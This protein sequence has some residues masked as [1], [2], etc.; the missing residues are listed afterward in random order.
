M[1]LID[2]GETQSKTT[3]LA[4]NSDYFDEGGKRNRLNVEFIFRAIGD[5]YIL[6]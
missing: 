2:Q 3:L 4:V 1:R 6:R 5:V